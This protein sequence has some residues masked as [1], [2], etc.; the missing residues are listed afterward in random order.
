MATLQINNL[1]VDYDLVRVL[2]DVSITVMPGTI[3]AL[4]GANGAGKTTLLKTVSGLIQPSKGSIIFDGQ[5]IDKIK[6]HSIVRMGISLVSEGHTVF[7]DL[8]V[9][10]NLRMGAYILSNREEIKKSIDDILN[11]F[12]RL[13]ERIHQS[14]GTL[15]GGEQQMLAIARALVCKPK[16]LMLDEPSLGLAPLVMGQVFEKIKEINKNGTTILLVEQNARLALNLSDEAYI[17][18]VGEIILKGGA[19]E[20]INNPSIKLSYLGG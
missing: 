4:I 11:I 12:P 9:W 13:A 15:S 1:N 2:H 6:S 20:L 14:A 18:R 16:L 8:S 7:T 19:K 17:L 5:R 3:T 10:E